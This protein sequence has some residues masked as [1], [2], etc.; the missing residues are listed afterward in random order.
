MNNGKPFPPP[1]PSS[2]FNPSLLLSFTILTRS[3]HPRTQH[4]FFS[5]QAQSLQT[6][7]ME[8]TPQ[9]FCL[10]PTWH[11]PVQQ[12]TQRCSKFIY[13]K[14]A[15][16]ALLPHSTMVSLQVASRCWYLTPPGI[17]RPSGAW[18]NL[19]FPT[20]SGVP[21]S[22]T[23]PFSSPWVSLSASLS[24]HQAPPEISLPAHRRLSR[25][26]TFISFPTI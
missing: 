6:R 12:S 5:V 23:C 15:F 24:Q 14:A 25:M 17:Q 26:Y 18:R 8:T 22:H 21:S 7:V 13:H 1:P 10:T 20:P 19:A 2:I 11:L 9:A 4:F 16:S 3:Y